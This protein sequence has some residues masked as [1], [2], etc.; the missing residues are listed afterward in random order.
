MESA[1][2]SPN[3]RDPAST[4]SYLFDIAS[5]KMQFVAENKGMGGITEVSP[6]ASMRCF[7]V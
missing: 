5:G 3:R 2:L 6:M 4:D 7:S 1:S